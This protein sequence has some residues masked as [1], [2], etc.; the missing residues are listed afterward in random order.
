MSINKFKAEGQNDE[1]RL[2]GELIVEFLHSDEPL[3]TALRQAIGD[4]KL[5]Q[6]AEVINKVT[7][8]QKP[9]TID[10]WVTGEDVMQLLHISPRTMQTLR[11]NGTLPF[12]KIGN[13]IFYRN[14]DVLKVLHDNY[15]MRRL[16]NPNGYGAERV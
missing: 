5:P 6:T 16:K 14:E 3:A 8:Q 15:T 2:I 7:M 1:P 12:S 9:E 13:K 4:G 10:D 11:D